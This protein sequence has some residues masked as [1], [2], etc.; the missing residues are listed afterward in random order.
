MESQK[1]IHKKTG[2]V[3]TQVP[4]MEMENYRKYY[5]TCFNCGSE[6]DEHGRC[7]YKGDD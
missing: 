2:E 1:F 7:G 6:I 5:G 3:V 4:I